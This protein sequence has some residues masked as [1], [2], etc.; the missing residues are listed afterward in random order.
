MIPKNVIGAGIDRVDG[1]LKVT[2]GAKYAGDVSLD[3]MV[4]AVPVTSTIARGN[5]ASMETSAA[6]KAPGVRI[7]MTQENAVMVTRRHA[8]A[9]RDGM[10]AGA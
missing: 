4:Y 2:G 10:E 1:P 5:I 6:V 7:V 9:G 8:G 3:G